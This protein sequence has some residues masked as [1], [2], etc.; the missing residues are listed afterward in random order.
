MHKLTSLKLIVMTMWWYHPSKT[1]K[2]FSKMWPQRQ[3]FVFI[4][5]TFF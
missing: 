3:R 2:I 4:P 5:Q 1:A